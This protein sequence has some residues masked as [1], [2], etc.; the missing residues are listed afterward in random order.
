M[1]RHKRATAAAA[2]GARPDPLNFWSSV[3]GGSPP[4][5]PPWRDSRYF[6]ADGAAIVSCLTI[7]FSP[8]FS[9]LSLATCST[10]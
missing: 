9:G 4:L 2:A 7:L 1:R 3:P 10:K 8:H 6:F 5:L